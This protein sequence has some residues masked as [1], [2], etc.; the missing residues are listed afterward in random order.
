MRLI[1]FFLAALLFVSP[2]NAGS[3]T[4]LGAGVPSVVSTPFSITLASYASDAGNAAS[5]N[6]GS[7]TYG[8]GCTRV[9]AGII[10]FGGGV[11]AVTGISVGGTALVQIPGAAVSDISV[12]ADVWQSSAALAGTSGTVIAD[13]VSPIG[14]NGVTIALHCLVTTTPAATPTPQVDASGFSSTTTAT[15]VVPAGGG[16]IALTAGG[17]G[18]TLSSLTNTT[19]LQ[20]VNTPAPSA[21]YYA[22]ISG[23]GSKTVLGIYNGSQFLCLSLVT[24]AP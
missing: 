5:I 1:Q 16:G 19:S 23:T 22:N 17:G 8:S 6:F 4:L 11:P 2:V 14:T 21:T 18:V 9:V 13:F 7:M 20:T 24:W 10:Y 3:L 15:I 12:A